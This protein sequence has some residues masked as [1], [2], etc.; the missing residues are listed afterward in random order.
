MIRVGT[1]R[2]PVEVTLR[3]PYADVSVT[4]R[5]LTSSEYGEARQAANAIVR[6]NSLLIELMVKHDL[7]PE[8]GV[9]AWKT[10]KDRD[11]VGYAR[12]LTGIAVWL[13][14]VECAVRGIMAWK[15]ILDDEGKP[16]PVNREAIE[17]LMLDE[18]FS[19]QVMTR[20]DEAAR[21]LIVEGER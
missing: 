17:V 1:N 2:E 6:D 18:G 12:F 10:M 15:G 13:G 20:L 4:L 8:G 9:K 14:S 16:A 11:V 5:R 19:D 7:L 3:P 21:I